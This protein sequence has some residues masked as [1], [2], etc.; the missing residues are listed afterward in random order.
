M[1][2]SDIL[3]EVIEDTDDM[4]EGSRFYLEEVKDNYYIGLWVFMGGSYNVKVEKK[5]CKILK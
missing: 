2:N 3:V 1:N 5:Y 4:P